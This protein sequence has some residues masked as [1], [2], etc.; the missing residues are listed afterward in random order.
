[1]DVDILQPLLERIHGATFATL[2]TQTTTKNLL[3]VSKGE[4]VILFRTQGV[5]GYENRVKKLLSEA[6]LGPS[7]FSVGPLPW[8]VRVDDLPLISHKGNYYLQCVRLSEPKAE[9]FLPGGIPVSDL[10]VYGVRERT[11]N[12]DLPEDKQVHVS[13]YNVENITRIALMGEEV[14]DTNVAAKSQR[15]ILKLNYNK[16]D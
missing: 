15:A 10:S 13:C 5:S 12:L 7:R 11:R 2:D 1:M 9:Y 6:G 16:K 14:F 3:K 8:G 4:R